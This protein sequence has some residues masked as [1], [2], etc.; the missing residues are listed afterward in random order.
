MGALLNGRSSQST[1]GECSTKLRNW[2]ASSGAGDI[3]GT[4][5]PPGESVAIMA[6]MDEIRKQIGLTYEADAAVGGK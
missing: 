5:L 2:N 6:V 1:A 3:A 4:I